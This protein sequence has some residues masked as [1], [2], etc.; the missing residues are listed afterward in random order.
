MRAIW[1]LPMFAGAALGA[2]P[3]GAIDATKVDRALVKEPRYE[4]RAP[5]YCLVVLGP[6]A[7][8]WLVLDG[9]T[10]YVDRNG[11]GDLTE[12]GERIAGSP[13]LLTGLLRPGQAEPKSLTYRSLA[14]KGWSVEV[15][16]IDGVPIQVDVTDEGR[17]RTFT[18]YHDEQGPLRFADRPAGAPII[19]A[20]GRLVMDLDE[21]AHEPLRR[22]DK[23]TN[24]M[25]TIGVPGSGPGSFAVIHCEDVPKEL[26]PVAEV[27][28]PRKGGGPP[29]R[30]RY[31]L[32]QRC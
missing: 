1:L 7:H 26:H 23:P 30:A 28:F 14:M 6:E 29:V 12:A 8:V 5:K 15:L 2:V 20:A 9:E 19:H 10:M 27:E 31:V 21:K 25:T 17:K 3:A 13:V 18:G 16:V 24:L 22:G 32:G 11:N 4:T